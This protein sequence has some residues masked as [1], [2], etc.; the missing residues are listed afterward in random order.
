MNVKSLEFCRSLSENASWRASVINVNNQHF[1]ADLRTPA[2]SLLLESAKGAAARHQSERELTGS[3]GGAI[4]SATVLR[5]F[6]ES[7]G[8]PPSREKLLVHLLEAL[9]NFSD[10]LASGGTN[11][12]LRAFS[13]AST[14]V[15]DRRI[16]VEEN[17]LRGTTAG[18]DSHGFLLVRSA[19][20]HTRRIS[21]GGVRLDPEGAG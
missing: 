15:A 14:Y 10:L 8:R 5:E 4:D 9:D 2:T 18:L 7:G 3:S 13:A 6:L 20:G 11:A 19:D 17:G 1:P 16:I 21:S 12:I